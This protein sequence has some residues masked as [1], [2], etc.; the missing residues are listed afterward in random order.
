MRD[1]PGRDAGQ[2]GSEAKSGPEEP[3]ERE[4]RGV[5]RVRRVRDKKSPLR[6]E[7]GSGE[8]KG[9]SVDYLLWLIWAWAAARRA[10][11]TRKGEQLT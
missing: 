10:M 8:M 11:G 4:G 6:G 5:W 9:M 1:S 3:E 7:P 2:D